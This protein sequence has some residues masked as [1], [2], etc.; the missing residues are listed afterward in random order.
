MLKNRNI[1]L[2]VVALALV[3][4]FSFAVETH[5]EP[6]DLY[7]FEFPAYVP[8]FN[9][10]ENN[11]T[12]VQGVN[13]GRKLFF[14][15]TLSGDNSVSCAGCHNPKL[16]FSD[17]GNK[18]SKGI[19][20]YLTRRNSMSLVNL[21]WNNAFFWDGRVKT[22]EELV[23]IPITDS[24]EMGEN[25]PHLIEELEASAD[26][27]K[28]FYEAFG[29]DEITG[30]RISRAIAQYLRTLI[31]FNSKMDVIY[32]MEYY[33]M[34]EIPATYGRYVDEEFKLFVKEHFSAENEQV[35]AVCAS[36]HGEFL[37]GGMEFRNNGLGGDTPEPGLSAFSKNADD[38]GKFKAV[39]LRNVSL[40]APYMHDGRFATLEA[41]LDHYENHVSGAKNADATFFE[42]N[43]QKPKINK[44]SSAQKKHLLK[45]LEYMTDTTFITNN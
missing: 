29:T 30:D 18:Y 16:A 12:T 36:C 39:S 35:I 24:L 15:Q 26:Y 43:T 21:G 1:S 7:K 9:E 3:I 40:T 31:S 10:P 22:L 42:Y 8:K 33:G 4:F 13:L 5:K 25:V 2:L 44:L 41:V 17:A 23:L 19:H 20:G 45:T 28:M 14:D 37:Y 27:R 11:K 34:E 38:L 32:S 6:V